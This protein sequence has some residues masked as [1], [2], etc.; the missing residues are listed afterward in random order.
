MRPYLVKTTVL[1]G[2]KY[3]GI[4]LLASL[5]SQK[6]LNMMPIQGNRKGE[7]GVAAILPS[8]MEASYCTSG[9]FFVGKPTKLYR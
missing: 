5:A 4:S 8:H 1:Y 6:F 9:F 2:L 3:L 7:S